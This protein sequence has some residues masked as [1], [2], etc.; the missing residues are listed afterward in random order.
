MVTAIFSFGKHRIRQLPSPATRRIASGRIVVAREPIS[1]NDSDAIHRLRI[2]FGPK[3]SELNPE[4]PEL[5]EA[6]GACR[7][8]FHRL[9]SRSRN[10]RPLE[11]KLASF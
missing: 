2:S 9:E 4:Q 7:S 3:K 1:C 6:G 11:K 8:S 5:T 10:K